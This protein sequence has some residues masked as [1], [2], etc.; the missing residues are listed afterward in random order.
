MTQEDVIR[1]IHEVEGTQAQAAF[2]NHYDQAPTRPI[3]APDQNRTVST[4]RTVVSAA[5]PSPRSL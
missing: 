5:P 4:T 2:N 1:L 3:E